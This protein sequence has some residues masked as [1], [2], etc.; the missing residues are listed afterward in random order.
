MTKSISL[1]PGVQ[2]FYESC[3]GDAN[4]EGATGML[5]IF[6]AAGNTPENLRKQIERFQNIFG[7]NAFEILDRG[8]TLKGEMGT[9]ELAALI[10]ELTKKGNHVLFGTVMTD[11]QLDQALSSQAVGIASPTSKMDFAEKAAAH[12]GGA[13]MAAVTAFNVS[14]LHAA[15]Q[16]GLAQQYGNPI[17]AEHVPPELIVAKISPAEIALNA[18]YPLKTVIQNSGARRA[19]LAF[20]SPGMTPEMA[21]ALLEEYGPLVYDAAVNVR[22]AVAMVIRDDLTQLEILQQRIRESSVPSRWDAKVG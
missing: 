20:T 19:S 10:K 1:A 13:K 14:D 16:E 4:K 18:Q 5:P 22:M 7:I 9:D 11:W 12:S 17:R 15:V 6:N 3:Y 8:D 2:K 21:E